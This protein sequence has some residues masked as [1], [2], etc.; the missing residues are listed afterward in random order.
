M[1]EGVV[2]GPI[3]SRDVAEM[4]AFLRIQHREQAWGYTERK[5]KEQYLRIAVKKLDEEDAEFQYMSSIEQL[6]LAVERAKQ[7]AVDQANDENV[8]F[9]MDA[10]G[11]VLD[12]EGNVDP[13][14]ARPGREA[15][16]MDGSAGEV[17]ETR[18]RGSVSAKPKTF[19]R[20]AGRQP[21]E[22]R[23]KRDT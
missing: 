21:R 15:R 22:R 16:F 3:T 9:A 19:S 14:G 18:E 2:D 8:F 7:I 6:H 10:E 4:R 12:E 13:E 1:R 23:P 11:N 17:G 5:K 20:G